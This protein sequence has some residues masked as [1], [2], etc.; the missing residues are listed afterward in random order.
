[1]NIHRKSILTALCVP[2]A[3]FRRHD[4]SAKD[5][6]IFCSLIYVASL[7]MVSLLP[8]LIRMS[9]RLYRAASLTLGII[10]LFLYLMTFF[11]NRD[12]NRPLFFYSIMYL[13]L[14]FLSMA[15]DIAPFRL[16]DYKRG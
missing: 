16:L 3:V 14:I 7:L 4:I 8:D 11:S 1:M 6:I 10:Y 12:L 2:N 9:G 13:S 15:I 5:E